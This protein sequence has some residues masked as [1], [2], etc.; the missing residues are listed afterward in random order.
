[1]PTASVRGETHH[2]KNAELYPP[3]VQGKKRLAADTFH[4]NKS[5]CV[6]MDTDTFGKGISVSPDT[7][8]HWQGAMSRQQPA[9][10]VARPDEAE[11]AAAPPPSPPHPKCAPVLTPTPS[12][13]DTSRVDVPRLMHGPV[14]LSCAPSTGVSARCTQDDVCL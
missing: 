6:K 13:S 2:K 5:F 3:Q 12:A 11:A 1:M 14:P 4:Q 8:S 7:T 10:S 9:L